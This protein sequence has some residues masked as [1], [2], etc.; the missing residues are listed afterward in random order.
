[1]DDVFSAFTTSDGRHVPNL[2][3]PATGVT[4]D[5]EVRGGYPVIE[6]TRI[7]FHVVAG[8]RADGMPPEEIAELYPSVSPV[9]VEG[10]VELAQLVAQTTK[11]ISTAA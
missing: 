6:G 7:P 3:E 11:R 8:L 4:I 10:A 9:D 5:P 1:M 2:G